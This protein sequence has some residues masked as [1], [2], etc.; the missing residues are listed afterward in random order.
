MNDFVVIKC[1]LKLSVEKVR[2]Y[3]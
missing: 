2:K 1:S 3:R